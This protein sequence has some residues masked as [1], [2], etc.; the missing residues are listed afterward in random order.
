MWPCTA[1]S[2]P[3][4]SPLP[5]PTTTCPSATAPSWRD[6]TPPWFSKP[7]SVGSGPSAD[8]STSASTSPTARGPVPFTVSTSRSPSPSCASPLAPGNVR[9]TIWNPAQTASTTAPSGDA[10]RQRPVVDERAGGPNLGA[11]LSPSQAVEVR[12]G[13]GAVRGGL[14][15]ARPRGRAIPPAAPGPARSHR[16]RRCP[17]G[18]GRRPRCAAAPS[19]RR[20]QQVVEGGV[21]PDDVDHA[22]P[23]L[24][25]A[26]ATACTGSGSVLWP[27]PP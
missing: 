23:L 3:S 9:P 27:T 18:P 13:E 22:P 2:L 5:T 11:V 17:G 15:A 12:L 25:Q 1:P 24:R 6:V 20:A 26:R 16:R 14:R 8:G 19:C 7:V 4:P 10:A 21:V